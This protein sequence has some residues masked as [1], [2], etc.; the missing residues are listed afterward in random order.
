MILSLTLLLLTPPPPDCRNPGTWATQTVPQE[1]AVRPLEIPETEMNRAL[2]EAVRELRAIDRANRG[3]NAEQKLMAS[4]RAWIA[5]RGA[6][7]ALAGLQAIDVDLQG[8]LVDRCRV[9]MTE[10]RTM[11]LRTFTRR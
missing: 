6:H 10:Q 9:E 11:D 3:L 4:Q 7:C 5:Y 1:C 2:A 8:T